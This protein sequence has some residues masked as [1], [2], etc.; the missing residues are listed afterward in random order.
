MPENTV[1]LARETASKVDQILDL[2][3]G[4]ELTPGLIALVQLHEKEIEQLKRSS[5]S[6]NVST[7][8]LVGVAWL[9]M[10]LIPFLTLF[11]RM[12]LISEISHSLGLYGMPA[13]AVSL[14]LGLLAHVILIF[15]V[16]VFVLRW[17]GAAGV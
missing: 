4:N 2:L 16:V 10:F 17:I 13:V 15:V 1:D 7:S 3:K 5:S 11:D 12:V 9:G 8:T 6:S 14:F